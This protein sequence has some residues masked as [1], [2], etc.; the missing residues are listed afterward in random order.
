MLG[1]FPVKTQTLH[2]ANTWCAAEKKNKV[3]L[4]GG[5]RVWGSEG[6]AISLFRAKFAVSQGVS[7]GRDRREAPFFS[8]QPLASSLQPP[9]WPSMSQG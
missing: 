7:E 4:G 5:G 1:E 8:L 2:M 6:V 3:G 9:P